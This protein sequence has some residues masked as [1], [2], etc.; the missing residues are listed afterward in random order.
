M[1]ILGN[2]FAGASKLNYLSVLSTS[3]PYILLYP[4]VRGTGIGTKFSD[5]S[6]AA[7]APTSSRQSSKFST[8]SN[9]FIASGSSSPYMQ[10]Y[11]VTRTGFGT[12]VSNPSTLLTT[13]A[14]AVNFT[15][16]NNDVVANKN[17][18]PSAWSWTNSGF[19]TK[20]TDSSTVMTYANTYS[21]T[22]NSVGDDVFQGGSQS[23]NLMNAW[24]FISG[25]GWGSQYSSPSYLSSGVNYQGYS[26]NPTGNLLMVAGVTPRVQL[27]SWTTGTGFGTQ[28]AT[29]NAIDESYRG[30]FNQ[31]GSFYLNVNSNINAGTPFVFFQA[32][33]VS[34]SG[35]GT[36][37]S[38]PYLTTPIGSTVFYNGKF[39]PY[40]TEIA[41]ATNLSNSIY[42]YPFTGSS[43]GTKYSDP[44]TLPSATVI[45][46]QFG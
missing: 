22:V 1:P 9:Y 15:P 11:P 45:D 10:V 16:S 8:S 4:W 32:I 23:T 43:F 13:S 7:V 2:V 28:I 3:S 24:A 44:A 40:G 20:Y 33:P 14:I 39:S 41:M 30:S 19:G 6:V 21:G 12:K 18:V 29:S 37:I 36:T 35:F 26:T 27:I 5:P 25:T 42:T 17:S 38:G 31:T 46:V 34:T